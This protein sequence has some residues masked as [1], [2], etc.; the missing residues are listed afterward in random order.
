MRL[1]SLA[2]FLPAALR[3]FLPIGHGVA[4]RLRRRPSAPR[5][6]QSFGI[7]AIE[8]IDDA[9]EARDIAGPRAVDEK[10]NGGAVR[11][12]VCMGDPDGLEIGIAVAGS[13]VGQQGFLAGYPERHGNRLHPLLAAGLDNGA[14]AALES[15]GDELWED[16]FERL[17]LEMIEQDLRHAFSSLFRSVRR[18]AGSAGEHPSPSPSSG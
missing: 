2:L 13:A 7:L 18:R 15:L 11:R 6:G 9:L 4:C 3:V 8:E 14:P 17:A 10:A 1:G 16:A 12:F 5:L